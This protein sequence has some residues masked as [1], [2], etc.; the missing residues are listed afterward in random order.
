MKFIFRL[1][2]TSAIGIKNGKARSVKGRHEGS[3]LKDVEDVCGEMGITTGEIWIDGNGKVSFS[4]EI[5][6]RAHQRFRNLIVGIHG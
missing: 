3:L 5:P 1:S 2:A 6:K 4:S